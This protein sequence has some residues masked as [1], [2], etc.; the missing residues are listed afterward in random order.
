MIVSVASGKGGTGKTL[1]ATSL[2]LSLA[3]PTADVQFVDCDVEE[4]NGHLF[5]KPALT[6]RESV[7][8]PIPVVD[9]DKCTY[10][11]R[12]SEVCAFNA[13]AVAGKQV[14]VFPELCH[15]CGACSYLCPEEAISEKGRQVGVVESGRAGAVAFVHGK[16]NV[17]E[18]MAAVV[19]LARFSMAFQSVPRHRGNRDASSMASMVA[20]YALMRSR[21]SSMGIATGI[22]S[23]P[24]PVNVWDTSGS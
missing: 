13:I 18:P 3:G 12:C 16:L 6:R 11:G 7:E 10:C 9:F 22:C 21:T 20:S 1:V 5:L 4:P 23:G 17:G 19:I 2:A 24:N 8:I 14:L 15:G